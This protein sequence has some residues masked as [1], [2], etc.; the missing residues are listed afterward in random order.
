M[1]FK[2][3]DHV[4]LF[5]DEKGI[6]VSGE[7]FLPDVE[8]IRF[9]NDMPRQIISVKEVQE[10]SGKLSKYTITMSN[11]HVTTFYGELALYEDYVSKN[12]VVAA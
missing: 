3:N 6:Y 7:L 1:P 9:S 4:I 2:H 12:E 5:N 8:R 11:G 10:V